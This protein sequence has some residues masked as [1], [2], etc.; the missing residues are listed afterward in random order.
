MKKLVLIVMAIGLAAG[1]AVQKEWTAVGGSRAD[2]TV[3]MAYEYG[4]FQ[5]P[6]VDD[7]EGAQAAGASC[8]N[9]GY[10][11]AQPFGGVLRTCEARDGYGN[12]TQFLVQKKF[13]CLGAPDSGRANAAAAAR[14]QL[15]FWR[16]PFD[17]GP[18][19]TPGEN[20]E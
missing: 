11:M 18:A 5:S 14:G 2:G 8:A 6:H 3:T 7:A 1:C 20:V 13:Q 17:Q 4:M 9:W 12:C 19:H 10:T 16:R 15:R